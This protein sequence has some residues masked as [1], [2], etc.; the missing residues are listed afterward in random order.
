MPHRA[1]HARRQVKRPEPLRVSWGYPEERF[2][3]LCIPIIRDE[4]PD[5]IISSHFGSAPLFMVVDT[6]A[7]TR[8]AVVNLNVHHEHGR[9]NPIDLLSRE[10]LDAVVVRGIGRNAL[11]RL[12]Q[13]GLDVICTECATVS[14]AVAAFEAGLLL[15][16]LAAHACGGRHLEEG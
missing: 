3:R 1:R 6:S 2:V 12:R 5:S 16:V 15:P 13:A 9:C 10:R 4:G 14:E 8:A 7:G 11:S